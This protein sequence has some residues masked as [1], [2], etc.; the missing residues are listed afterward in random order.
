MSKTI[1]TIKYTFVYVLILLAI[2]ALGAFAILAHEASANTVATYAP[3]NQPNLNQHDA[4]DDINP[5][6]VVSSL[7]PNS[8]NS[9]SGPRTVTISGSGFIPDS[10]A[11]FNGLDRNTTF[12][13]SSHLLINLTS[14][15]M[16]GSSGRYVT[17]WNPAPEGG[18]SNG[19]LFT[20]NGYVDPSQKST[21]VKTSG[22]AASTTSSSRTTTS[23]RTTSSRTSANTNNNGSV[24]G[25]QSSTGNDN[26]SALTGNVLYGTNSFMPSGIIQWLLLAIFILL[27][28]IIVRKIFFAD[29][30]HA[31]PMK[32]A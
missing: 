2:L 8:A 14:N 18:Y 32:H 29:K 27:I 19:V 31:T 12:I 3:Y 6:P 1:N 25:A 16:N 26:F 20:I 7:S 10:V 23:T 11:R 24:L 30:Y 13:D 9:G 21:I 28:V 17:V 22:G 5:K 4:S 15:D